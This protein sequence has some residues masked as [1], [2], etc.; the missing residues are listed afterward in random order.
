MRAKAIMAEDFFIKI[1]PMPKCETSF[2]FKNRVFRRNHVGNDPVNRVDSSGLFNTQLI[3]GHGQW[4]VGSGLQIIAPFLGTW[5]GVASGGL[6]AYPVAI[7]GTI[8]AYEYGENLKRR[9]IDT[10][11][12]EY[13]RRAACG[14][15]NGE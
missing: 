7:L 13:T 3:I 12:S 1:Q 8:K 15:T 6:L 5:I 9:G 11:T 2:G 4:L 14:G 10:I